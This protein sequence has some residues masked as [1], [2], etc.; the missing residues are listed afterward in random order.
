MIHIKGLEIPWPSCEY[1]T[2]HL[3]DQRRRLR[4]GGG[5]CQ[6]TGKIFLGRS[7]C[8]QRVAVARDFHRT[9]ERPS[10]N[11]V[12]RAFRGAADSRRGLAYSVGT[13]GRGAPRPQKNQGPHST[14]PCGPQQIKFRRYLLSHFWHYHRLWKL[15]Y[16]V[17]DGNG[18]DLPD[19][20]T[21]K[22][23]LVAAE[24]QQNK[25]SW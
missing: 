6:H 24:R 11:R 16:R 1:P 23:R 22:Y 7:P 8:A 20:V 12:S 13:S 4:A 19:M 15:N 5:G 18:C 9:S 21:G 10:A 2:R 3:P 17:R 25:G 14:Q